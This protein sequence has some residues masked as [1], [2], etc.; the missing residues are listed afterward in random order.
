[1]TDLEIASVEAIADWIETATLVSM[2]GH[3]GRDRLEE[4]ASVEIGAPPLKVSM[5]MEVMAK[6][7]KVLGSAYP[8]RTSEL[9]VLRENG[10]PLLTHYAALL[11]LTPGSVARQTVRATDAAEMGELFE[12][13]AEK[14]LANLWGEGG[15][16]LSF[17]YPS[18]HGRPEAFDQAVPWLASKIGLEPGRGYRP[19][20]RKDGGV[21]VVAWRQFADQ[22]PGF[23]L[24]LAQCTIQAETFRKTTDIDLRLW[25]SWLA[26][27]LDPM[28]LLVIPGTVRNAGPD[29]R[30]LTT[31][32]TVIERMRLMELLNRSAKRLDP[33]EWSCE[34]TSRLRSFMKA[35]EA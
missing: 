3:L 6:R 19:P 14:A 26:M 32:V 10:N 9:A 21:D 17:G 8:F 16:A 2:S 29:W 34:T 27:D 12:T 35:A 7:V 5:A 33:I 24:G 23:P 25:A 13:I 11:H 30:Q 31:V 20:L 15:R 22:R 18:R 4:L 28:S 1:M